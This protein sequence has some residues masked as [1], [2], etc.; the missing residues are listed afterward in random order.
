MTLLIV[1][2]Q[3]VVGFLFSVLPQ[4]PTEDSTNCKWDATVQG[5]GVGRSFITLHDKV[6]FTN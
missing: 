1:V 3:I 5:N 2:M 6:I 4:C